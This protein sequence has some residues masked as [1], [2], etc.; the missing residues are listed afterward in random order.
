MGKTAKDG[1]PWERRSKAPTRT[2]DPIRA[3]RAPGNLWF[4]RWARATTAKVATPMPRAQPF[5]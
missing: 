1:T 3:M 2:V 5:R 4:N